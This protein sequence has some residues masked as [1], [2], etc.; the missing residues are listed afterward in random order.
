MTA[1][2]EKYRNLGTG[3]IFTVVAV[4]SVHVG[5]YDKHAKVVVLDD[6]MRWEDGQRT[7]L[8]P[9]FRAVNVRETRSFLPPRKICAKLMRRGRSIDDG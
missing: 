4:E 1:V 2:G 3:E 6:G 8:N 7:G 5:P 9:Q